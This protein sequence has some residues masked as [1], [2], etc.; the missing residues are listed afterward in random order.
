M[1]RTVAELHDYVR[2]PK[3]VDVGRMFVRRPDGEIELH[4]RGKHKGEP[5]TEVAIRDS[6]YLDWMLS[7]TF[8]DDAKAMKEAAALKQTAPKRIIPWLCL[9]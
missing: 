7:D 2:D 4:P 5:L 3:A 8:L 9:F 6:R 1:P